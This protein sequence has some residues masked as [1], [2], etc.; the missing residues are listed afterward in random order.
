MTDPID[1]P[2]VLAIAWGRVPAA[3]RG[4]RAGL[5]AAAIVDAAIAVGDAE[6]LAAISMG[7]IADRLGYTPMSLYRHVP[8]KE[9]L[10]ALVQDATF[11]DPPAAPPPDGWR[12]GLAEW[13]TAV[14]AR[15][16]EHVWA[17]DIPI[18]GP[19]AMPHQI[20]WFERALAI[21]APTPLRLE[22][23][24]SIVLL[25][26][27]YTRQWAML[28]RDLGRG[29]VG[30]A[31]GGSPDPARDYQR[32][33]EAVVDPDRFPAVRAAIAG[34]M[35]TDDV[36]AGWSNGATGADEMD[37]LEGEFAFGLDRILDG[38]AVYVDRQ[39]G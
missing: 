35:L 33:L 16:R 27:G 5:D 20:A 9:A 24:L 12:P 13:A 4:P 32:T 8:S 14:L 3:T 22:E 1:I 36:E 25:V 34:G 2:P 11:G 30:A 7:R 28:T 19:P 37:D 26:S 15:Y 17:L 10:L 29:Y 23:Q 31:A 21:L 39:A 38:V 18:S 6:G